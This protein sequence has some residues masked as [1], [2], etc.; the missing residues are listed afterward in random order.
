[1]CKIFRKIVIL[2]ALKIL[3]SII[4]V[5]NSFCLKLYFTTFLTF[6]PTPPTEPMDPGGPCGPYS[7]EKNTVVLILV[8]K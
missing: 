3:A 2:Y 8:I 5:L 7:V 1:M 6:S 4:R